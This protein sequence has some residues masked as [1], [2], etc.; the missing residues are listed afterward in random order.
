[1]GGFRHDVEYALRV[2]A[3]RPLFAMVAA[4]SLA[5]GIGA[6]TAIFSVANAILLRPLPGIEAQDRVVELGRGTD[7]RG[8][9]T[10][11]WPD[12][13]DIR[14]GV[15]ELEDAAV[16]HTEIDRRRSIRAYPPDAFGA[17]KLREAVKLEME[18]GG[19][20]TLIVVEGANI[21]GMTNDEV[22]DIKAQAQELAA[23][24]WLSVAMP[25]EEVDGIPSVIERLD[26]LMSVVLALEPGPPGEEHVVLRAL[27]DHENPDVSALHVALDPQSLLL[28]RHH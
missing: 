7:G 26:D 9:D 2:L 6:N 17:P 25:G 11:A 23:E 21:A 16:T 10:F 1:M 22:A 24:V 13:E 14:D 20:P 19:K 27:K 3:R 5:V 28:V 18:A 8:F 15:P 4:L 12:Y